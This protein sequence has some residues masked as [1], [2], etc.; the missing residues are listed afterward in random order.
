[1]AI[2]CPLP[3]ICFKIGNVL[4]S[5][6]PLIFFVDSLQFDNKIVAFEIVVRNFNSV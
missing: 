3:P 4:Y 6:H 5:L 1:L 2:L